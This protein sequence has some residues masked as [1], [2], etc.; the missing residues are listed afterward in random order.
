VIQFLNVKNICP[1]KI[2]CQLV[3]VYGEGIMN[4][5]NVHEWCHLFK[6]GRTDVH[7]E[8]ESGCS[9]RSAS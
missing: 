8:A 7:N 4:D 3:E 6:G 1:A 2:H 5:G 9:C